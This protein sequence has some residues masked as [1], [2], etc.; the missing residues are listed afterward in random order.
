M[1]NLEQARKIANENGFEIIQMVGKTQAWGAKHLIKGDGFVYDAWVSYV[2]TDPLEVAKAAV[3]AKYNAWA[4]K[5]HR[6]TFLG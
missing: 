2:G 5:A 4:N 6:A 3:H 1:D